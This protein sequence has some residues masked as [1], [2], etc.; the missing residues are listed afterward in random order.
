[1]AI[2]TN[3]PVPPIMS[4]STL[5][6]NKAHQYNNMGMS[7]LYKTTNKGTGYLNKVSIPKMKTKQRTSNKDL[8]NF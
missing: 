3:Q 6:K 1:M 4:Q 5:K 7:T 8:F 2:R